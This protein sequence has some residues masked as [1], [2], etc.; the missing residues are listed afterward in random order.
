MKKTKLLILL[1]SIT[2]AMSLG[3]CSLFNNETIEVDPPYIEVIQTLKINLQSKTEKSLNPELLNSSV[4]KPAFIYKSSN[5]KV[6]TVSTKGVVKGLKVGTAK[7]TITLKT[8]TKVTETVTVNV[9]DQ[10][11]PHYDYTLMYYMAGSTLEY[12]PEKSTESKRKVGLISKDIKEILSVKN[13]PDSVRIIIQTG[14]AEKWCLE[15]SYLEGATQISGSKI[16]RWEVNNSTNKLTLIETLSTNKLATDLALTDY[17]DWALEDY[18]ADQMGLIFSG[19]GGG[20]AGCAYDDNYLDDYGYANT[21]NSAEMSKSFKNALKNS[22]KDKFTWVGYDCCLMQCADLA[23]V[24]A[25]YFDYMVASQELENGTGWD[26]DHYLNLVAQ[27]PSVTTDVLL[28]DIVD[29]FI[30][31]NHPAIENKYDE[32]CYQTLSVLDLSKMDEFIENF[33]MFCEA[34]GTDS[35]AYNKA[36]NAFKYSYNSFGESVFGLCDFKSLLNNFNSIYDYTVDSAI[37]SLD[38]LV[39]YK[40]NCSGYSVEPCGLNAFFPEKASSDKKDQLQVGELDYTDTYYAEASKLDLWQEMC[41]NY[42][43]FVW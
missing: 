11:K 25:D 14:G 39:I 28:K 37:S 22:N 21:L 18:E 6:A 12:D 9:V 15:S 35:N 29:S 1:S 30:N 19:H 42:G 41:L 26:H 43:S 8:N 23:S 36:K 10:T 7:I 17:L 5:T 20:L 3:S 34:L 27:N 2:C 38:K 13:I 16:Q 40:N 31:E 32:Y 4:T 33:N 24:N